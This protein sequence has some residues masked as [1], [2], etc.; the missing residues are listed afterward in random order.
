MVP[1]GTWRSG[2]KGESGVTWETPFSP[3]VSVLYMAPSSFY[4]QPRAV[5]IPI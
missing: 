1:G 2:R 5:C 4:L 3:H